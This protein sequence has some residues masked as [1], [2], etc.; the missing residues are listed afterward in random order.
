MKLTK[1]IWLVLGL[2]VGLMLAVDVARTR[3]E[4][5]E[6][7]SRE[8]E[9]EARNIHALVMAMRRV[10][11][12][13]FVKSGLPVTDATVGFLPAHSIARI[14]REFPNWSNSGIRFNN[15]SDR[16]R[17]PG[18]MADRF[19]MEAIDWFRA[20]PA[21]TERLRDIVEDNGVGYLHYAA[22][23]R[24]EAPCLKCH[25]ARAEAPAVIAEK[26][27]TAFDYRV[28][29]LRGIVSLR[30]PKAKIEERRTPAGAN[31]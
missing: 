29:D 26:Y 31:A 10:Y 17:N 14:A 11:Q 30:M 9:Y 27:D 7:A 2:L 28:G 8:S 18:N 3:H 19:E 13:Q 4:L 1:K 24:V 6:E 20:N 21:A 25:G 12:D 5:A 23:I 16:P 15:V 22:P